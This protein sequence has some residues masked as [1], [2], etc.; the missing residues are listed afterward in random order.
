M[1]LPKWLLPI[2]VLSLL[3]FATWIVMSHSAQ[4]ATNERQDQ[5][6]KDVRQI[7]SEIHEDVKELLQRVPRKP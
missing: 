2:L 1:K 3:S 7:V 6:M 4:A 5:E